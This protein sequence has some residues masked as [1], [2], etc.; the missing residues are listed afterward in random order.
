MSKAQRSS[1]KRVAQSR[2]PS[3][4][5]VQYIRKSILLN[6][7]VIFVISI[8]SNSIYYHFILNRTDLSIFHAQR[9]SWTSTKPKPSLKSLITWSPA[10]NYLEQSSKFKIKSYEHVFFPSFDQNDVKNEPDVPEPVSH[11]NKITGKL[12]NM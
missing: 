11:G 1:K 9:L 5:F 10:S 6:L 12:L 7:F 2:Q 3:P 8:L 4:T